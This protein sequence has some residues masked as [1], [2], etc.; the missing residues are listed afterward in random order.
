MGWRNKLHK[1]ETRKIWGLREAQIKEGERKA[2]KAREKLQ[3]KKRGGGGGGV[4]GISDGRETAGYCN[5]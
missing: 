3:R 4:G 1:W 5:R 2:F